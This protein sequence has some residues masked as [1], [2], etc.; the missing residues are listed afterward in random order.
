MGAIKTGAGAS[1]AGL[2][3]AASEGRTIHLSSP[4][5]RLFKSHKLDALLSPSQSHLHTSDITLL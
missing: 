1:L 3:Q 4:S 2:V 5:A